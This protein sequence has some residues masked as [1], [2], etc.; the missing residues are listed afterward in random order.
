MF[1]TIPA[2]PTHSCALLAHPAAIS[3]A[4]DYYTVFEEPPNFFEASWK[5]ANLSINPAP[6]RTPHPTHHNQPQNP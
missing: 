6:I 2:S 1:L 4:L 3:E 5:P